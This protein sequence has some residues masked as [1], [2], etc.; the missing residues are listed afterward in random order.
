[1]NLCKQEE[2]KAFYLVNPLNGFF[3]LSL[4]ITSL[5]PRQQIAMA[6]LPVGPD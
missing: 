5:I 1:M 6:L 3:N 2:K 4:K